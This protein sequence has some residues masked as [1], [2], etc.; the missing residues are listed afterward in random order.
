MHECS[1]AGQFFVYFSYS[2]ETQLVISSYILQQCVLWTHEGESDI[3]LYVK[4]KQ[5]HP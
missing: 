4:K 1:R 2:A 5:V 3:K